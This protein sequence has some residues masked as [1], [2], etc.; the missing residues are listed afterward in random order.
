MF[1]MLLRFRQNVYKKNYVVHILLVATFFKILKGKSQ[2]GL[3]FLARLPDKLGS[4]L[5]LRD[6]LRPGT[7]Q[8]FKPKTGK[9]RNCKKKLNGKTQNLSDQ[10]A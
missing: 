6:K 1:E 8:N 9:I 7:T 4:T 3:D 2:A 5:Y 10:F